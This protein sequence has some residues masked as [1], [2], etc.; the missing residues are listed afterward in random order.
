MTKL[1]KLSLCL[2]L[3]TVD[4]SSSYGTFPVKYIGNFITVEAYNNLTHCDSKICILDAQRLLADASYDSNDDPCVSFKN[5]SCGTFYH[6][7]ALNERYEIVGFQKNY[8]LRN[9]EKRHRVLKE[10]ISINDGKAARIVKNFY[11]KC[12]NWSELTSI[13]RGDDKEFY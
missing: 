6:E 13:N 12:I 7:R 8:E 2:F 1:N 4:V 9:L 5:F 11:Q 3:A 10:A